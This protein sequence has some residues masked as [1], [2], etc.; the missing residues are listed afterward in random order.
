MTTLSHSNGALPTLQLI[1]FERSAYNKR[2]KAMLYYSSRAKR[3][4]AIA[5]RLCEATGNTND[6]VTAVVTEVY[7]DE[8]NG[9]NHI[10]AQLRELIAAGAW[11]D[12]GLALIADKLPQWKLRRLIYDEGQW[13]C[14]LSLQPDLPD[15]LDQAIETSHWDLSLAIMSAFVEGLRQL[16]ETPKATRTPTV[17]RVRGTRGEVIFCE[18][19]A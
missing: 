10:P 13:H 5:N 4:I 17:P 12:A 3:L 16:P 19:F 2:C 11:T 15:W 7:R 14:A 9:Q 8:Q 1:A 6:L 18:N